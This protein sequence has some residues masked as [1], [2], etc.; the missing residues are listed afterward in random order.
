[1]DSR[2]RGNDI[3]DGGRRRA[4]IASLSFPII[5]FLLALVMVV[6]IGRVGLSITVAIIGATAVIILIVLGQI[7]L[8][9][10]LVIFA[11][12]YIDFYIG[13]RIVS[14]L[15]IL[16]LLG[17]SYL[18]RSAQRPWLEPRN[19]WLWGLFL[20]LA[21]FPAIRG[22]LTTHDLLIY[23]PDVVL[24]AFIMF[25]LGTIVARNYGALQR[26]FQLFAALGALMALHTII[27]ATTGVFLLALPRVEAYVA[28]VG[29]GLGSNTNVSRAESFLIDPN[30]NGTF[31]AMMIFIPI[32]L[33]VRS[34][35]L[36]GKIMYF[37][38]II[39]LVL[40]LLFTY[41]ASANISVLVGLAV[42]IVL[43]GNTRYRVQ[44][45][46][47]IGVAALVM[48]VGFPAQV[49][50]LLQHATDPGELTLRNAVWQTALNVIRA[51]PL[52]GLGLGHQAYL[53][54]AEPFRVAAQFIPL[55]HPHNSYLEWAAMAGI[56]V[57]CVFLAL[58]LATWWQALHN[59]FRV[60]TRT[61]SLI[62]AGIAATVTLSFCSWSNQGWTLPP[63][64]GLGWLLLGCVSSPLLVQQP[65]V[66][67]VQAKSDNAR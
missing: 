61:R 33:F 47:F 49:N 12:I 8:T 29:L 31:L 28:S 40:A 63:L 66:G 53:Q 58:V 56:P 36:I 42:F 39:A 37:V 13:Y 34:T 18:T 60:D 44:I 23:Y 26:A 10:T 32:A 43:V 7:E 45:L 22:A 24:G 17:I 51:Y 11:Q 2:L 41:S 38:E 35:S 65:H 50:L 30:W 55:D 48:L 62:A 4:R 16:L 14:L 54:G 21:I 5:A 46:L 67:P 19:L 59:W 3:N 15:L 64:A 20:A 57:L 25:W 1:M 52:T 27:E 9:V 6:V